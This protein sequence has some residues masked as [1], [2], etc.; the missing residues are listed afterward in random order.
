MAGAIDKKINETKQGLVDSP[1]MHIDARA[2]ILSDIALSREFAHTF[3]QALCKGHTGGKNEAGSTTTMSLHTICQAL[4]KQRMICYG[5]HTISTTSK[6]FSLPNYETVNGALTLTEANTSFFGYVC[7]DLDEKNTITLQN[8]AGTQT[9]DGNT[10]STQITDYYMVRSR[11]SG[12]L[13]S[14][15]GNLQAYV[16]PQDPDVDFGNT[17]AWGSSVAGEESANTWNYHWAKANIASTTVQNSGT[18]NQL[19]VLT[20][21]DHLTQGSNTNY[22]PVGP[23]FNNKFYL[24][25]HTDSMNTFTITGTTT[26]GSV[27]VSSISDADVL[28]IKIGDVISGT[29]ISGAPVI[30]AVQKDKNQLRMANTAAANGTVTIT[31][32]SVPFGHAAHDIFCQVEV[33]AEGLVANTTWTPVG[34]DAGGYATGSEDDLCVANTTQFISL[35]N[36]FDPAQ[37]GSNDLIKGA[38]A[39]YSS[40]GKESEAGSATTD[41][42]YAADIEI[43]PIKPSN[44]GTTKAFTLKDGEMTGTQPDGLGDQDVYVGRFVSWMKDKTTT[45]PSSSSW[46][47]SIPD[48]EYRYITDSAEK[49]FYMPARSKGYSSG[50]TTVAAESMPGNGPAPSEVEP[51]AVLPRTGMS[52]VTDRVITNDDTGSWG[53]NTATTT[54]PADAAITYHSS[55]SGGGIGP[56]SAGAGGVSG[57]VYGV[58][59]TRSG[60]TGSF[61]KLESNNF[62]TLNHVQAT[63]T[64]TANSTVTTYVLSYANQLDGPF[65]CYYNFVRQHVSGTDDSTDYA[66]VKATAS[67]LTAVDNFRDPIVTGAQAGGS[68]ISDSAFDGRAADFTANTVTAE[69]ALTA[70]NN[71]FAASGRAAHPEGGTGVLGTTLATGSAVNFASFTHSSVT[72][73][74]V[75]EWETL[76]TSAEALT[77]ACDKRVVEIDAR[78][79]VPT[80]AN[81]THAS[82]V[83]PA[84]RGNP[85]CIR[86]K[87]IPASNTTNGFVPYGRSIYNNVNLL[88]GG[89][90]DLLGKL[91]KDIESLG[92]LV[93]LIKTARNKYEIFN[94]RDKEY[95]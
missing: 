60:S 70:A 68:G 79:G 88:L 48:P 82:G 31:V 61:Y 23:G 92:D 62:I 11:V 91:I 20:L 67:A 28:K 46:P 76:K 66:F 2:A 17:I 25:K 73:N 18:V 75:T 6:K 81:S 83:T 47:T 4:A 9:I 45:T 84:T 29:G 49:F 51:R 19:N 39:D 89:D 52:T 80:Y 41:K 42:G 14:T 10:F 86:V 34:D 53:G 16:T 57:G 63:I 15:S 24:K 8:T 95:S 7:T 3:L 38:S 21:A 65:A 59:G 30:D 54:V 13:E 12:E 44:Q 69:A 43:N 26:T 94:G 40:S 36:F 56:N 33:S 58:S 55:L 77:D 64:T 90:V 5:A 78:I 72:Y 71:K 50:I 37:A 22:T 74:G 85:P 93:D 32:N 87:A 1:A 27:E 35:L